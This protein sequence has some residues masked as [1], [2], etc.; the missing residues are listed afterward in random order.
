MGPLM[1]PDAMVREDS[2][3]Y[4]ASNLAAIGFPVTGALGGGLGRLLMP[5]LE[6][7]A[8]G[9]KVESC[10]HESGLS[11]FR[12]QVQT[13]HLYMSTNSCFIPK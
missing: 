9:F 2:Y 11:S 10:G 8:A 3:V 12:S 7:G 6:Q 13:G 1:W 5:G 4:M